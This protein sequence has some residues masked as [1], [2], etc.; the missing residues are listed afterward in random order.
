MK[1]HFLSG[2]ILIHKPFV[3]FPGRLALMFIWEDGINYMPTPAESLD[4]NPIEMLWHDLKHFLISLHVI[5]CQRWRRSSCSKIY[6]EYYWVFLQN[7]CCIWQLGHKIAI[8]TVVG[9]LESTNLIWRCCISFS[10]FSRI[11]L[12]LLLL[13]FNLQD[14]TLRLVI[15]VHSTPTLFSPVY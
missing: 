14:K 12:L 6:P 9:T 15:L 10:I 11:F 8:I 13:Q 3:F 2:M 4:L 5:I 7:C 1:W